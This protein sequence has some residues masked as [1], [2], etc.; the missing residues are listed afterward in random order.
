MSTGVSVESE[1]IDL[2]A[3]ERFHLYP[4]ERLES[5]AAVSGFIG[6]LSGFYSGVKSSSLRYLTENG[7][8]LPR[9]VGGWYFY[10]KKKNYVMIVNGLKEGVKLGLKYSIAITGFFGLEWIIDTYIRRGTIDLFNTAAA[11]M[12]TSAA[13][14]IYHKL[15][16]IQAKSYIM[17]G[18]GL[19]LSLGFA[20][21]IMIHSRGGRIWYFDKLGFSKSKYAQETRTHDLKL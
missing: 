14:A 5:F 7:H 21:D 8:R 12:T 6:V 19:G 1:E 10:H 9:T 4:Q 2:K 20:Q 11:A 13:Y 15:S 18:A 3:N 16:R 17:R